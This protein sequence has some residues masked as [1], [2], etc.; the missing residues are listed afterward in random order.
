VEQKQVAEQLALQ[1]EFVVAQRRQ[2]AEQARQVAQGQ[3]DAVVI[4]AEGQ[5]EARLIQAEAEATALGMIAAAIRENPNLLTYLYIEKL[6]P[7]VDVMFLP[8]DAPFIFPLP[9]META[10]P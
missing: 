5:A 3:A 4:A 8:N 7:N 2:E 9:D 6:S 1:A 10:I